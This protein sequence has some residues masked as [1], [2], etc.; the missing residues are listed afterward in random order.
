MQRSWTLV[1]ARKS[2]TSFYR[3]RFWKLIVTRLQMLVWKISCMHVWKLIFKMKPTTSGKKHPT[4][5]LVGGCLL[6]QSVLWC[7]CSSSDKRGFRKKCQK[8]TVS[9]KFPGCHRH[10]VVRLLL[11]TSGTGHMFWCHQSVHINQGKLWGETELSVLQTFMEN[12]FLML[13][14]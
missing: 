9:L 4:C 14:T 7:H 1:S 5:K 2:L 3:G 10:R 8:Q 12:V 6:V 13:S 11:P